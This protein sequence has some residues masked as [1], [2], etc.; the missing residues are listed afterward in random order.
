[1]ITTKQAAGLVDRL[2]RAPNMTL[3]IGS[4]HLLTAEAAAMVRALDQERRL[5]REQCADAMAL[6]EWLAHYT[7]RRLKPEDEALYERIRA[8]LDAVEGSA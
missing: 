4:L 7:G 2:E 6:L 5:W 1:M 3:P 8:A